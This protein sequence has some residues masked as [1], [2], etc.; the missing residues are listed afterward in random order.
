MVLSEI[1]EAFRIGEEALRNAE[2]FLDID[3][4]T[5]ANRIYVAGENLARALILAVSGTCPRDHGK[6]WNAVQQ[7]YEKGI[8]KVN[9]KS[10]LETSYRLRIKGDYGKD[11][12]GV[13]VISK[14][15]IKEQIEKL[16]EFS[17]EV[18]RFIG[19][20]GK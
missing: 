17:K 7:L 16:K 13:V 8:I 5:A 14:E 10:V 12:G 15:I 6:V 9:Y 2:R 1:E 18:K 11:A 20:T 3:L 4:P 19:E